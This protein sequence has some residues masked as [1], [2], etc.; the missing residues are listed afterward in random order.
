MNSTRSAP[1][2]P[3]VIRCVVAA[4][5]AVALLHFSSLP[6][7]AA[8]GLYGNLTGVVLDA[9]SHAPIAG[10]RIEAKSPS[11]SYTATTNARGAFTILQ[12]NV[13]S[14]TVTVSAPGHETLNMQNVTVFGDET[15]TIGTVA[16]NAALKTIAKVTATSASSAFQPNQTVDTY[17]VTG[18]RIQQA[19]GNKYDT[20]EAALVQSAPGVIQTYDSAMGMSG[21]GLGSGIS[22]RGSLAVELGYQYDGVPFSAPFFNADA[23]QG[24]LNGIN[25][26][27]GGG[28]QIVSGA[29]DATQ[30]NVG[31]GVIN[32]IVPRG[33]YPSYGDADFEVGGPQYDH[34][35]NLDWGW[36][37][38][39]G[40]FS[41]YASF[42]G[43]SYVP[44]ANGPL[45]VPAA[46]LAIPG[47]SNPYFGYSLVR[48]NDFVDN[49]VFH[50]GK[51]NNQSLQ[52]LARVAY[53]D[54]W[55]GY[56]GLNGLSYF[57]SDP[58]FLGPFATCF[59]TGC[60][61]A[62]GPADMS[63]LQSLIPALPYAPSNPNA[64][65]TQGEQIAANPLH[66][67]KFGYTNELNPSTFLE[68]SAYN[69]GMFQGGSNYTNFL[70]AGFF[71]TG[72][73]VVGG[74]RTGFLG[75]IT[76]EFGD[77]NTMTVEA[78][79]DIAKPYWD[80]Q[81][82]GTDVF[83]LA[84]AELGAFGGPL[85]PNASDWALPANTAAPVSAANPCPITGGCYIYSAL[86]AAGKWTGTM[87]QV[88]SFGIGYH[89]TI[90]QNW[91]VGLRDQ[92]QLTD[93]LNLDFGA[94]VDGE[95]N[96][97]GPT[98][99]NGPGGTPSDVAPSKVGSAFISPREFEPRFAASYRLG[100]N[101]SIR[102]S[103][104]R[105]TLFFFGQTLGTPFNVTGINPLLLDIPAKSGTAPYCGSGT[106]GPGPGY[107]ANPA[108]PPNASLAPGSVG[109]FFPCQNYA[110]SVAWF[111]DQNFD[112]PD[113]GGYGPPTYSEFDLAWSHLFTK[114]LFN[115][116][117]SRITAY[118]RRGYNVEQNTL[119][120][121][122]PPN[123]IT[124]QSAASVFSTTANGNEKTFGIEAQLTT[125]D[126]H[127]GERGLS[128]FITFDYIN[129]LLNTPPVAGSSN[130]PIMPQ[131]LLLTG[132]MFKSG[133]V[134]PLSTVIGATYHF[135]SGLT[136]TPTIFA[137]GG[138]PFGVGTTS[139]GYVNGLLMT[140]PETNYGAPNL[141]YAG[142]SGPGNS[143]NASYFVD[144]QVPGSILNPN[145]AASRGYAEPTTAGLKNGPAEFF[146]NL[147]IEA[148]IARETVL[149]LQVFNLTGNHYGPPLVNTLYQPVATGVAGP[150]TGIPPTAGL[151]PGSAPEYYPG[152]GTLP[153]LNNYT[154]GTSWNVYLRT[155]V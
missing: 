83:G 99:F 29:G 26:G 71:G 43:S 59:T 81:G 150:L 45:G 140:T 95:Q 17:S 73:S 9:A 119:L 113:L 131:Q 2:L 5:I 136:I 80:N 23:A 37:T 39:N 79:Q 36:A 55:A 20:S 145:I 121:N 54:G 151:L 108:I 126:V 88:P 112:A 24:F 66:F 98:P 56:G 22:I 125:P 63:Y 85:S 33:T 6:A 7:F 96:K 34:T 38:P 148:P 11:G 1:G 53:L 58:N 89:N 116:W 61:N 147:D 102:F 68:L 86:Q 129:E 40:R 91:G 114:G 14:Y 130:L 48:H 52:V 149:G 128:G 13:D 115:G 107:T 90:Q 155:K 60:A 146:L 65:L 8:G 72:W 67:L 28:L 35:M 124:G 77:N 97:F 134:P 135:K 154:L 144:P 139:I 4:L 32:T 3:G 87:P 57:Q 142:Q 117:S 84:L 44:G 101:D 127:P 19:L 133:F 152:G 18:Q 78:S 69:W 105:S 143:Y 109:Y 31:G 50:F 10:A 75:S 25:G 46:E 16:L 104:G 100:R 41:N 49:A 153:F 74:T 137:N 103:Y 94:R 138:Y 30:G 110:A 12:M 122:G 93:K 132:Q 62:A 27:S 111:Y 92:W 21:V 47:T 123:P 51:N 118:T 82:P 64:L 141:P 120:L 106:H 70:N 15:D 42:S 76:H